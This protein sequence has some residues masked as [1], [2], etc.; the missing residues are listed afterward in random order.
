MCI[1]LNVHG[2]GSLIVTGFTVTNLSIWNSDLVNA[3]NGFML[4]IDGNAGNGIIMNE[5]KLTHPLFKLLIM[6]MVVQW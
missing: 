4:N 6:L 2:A 1:S 5:N 3:I